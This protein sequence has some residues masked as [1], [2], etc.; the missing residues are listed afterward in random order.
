MNR[1]ITGA[2]GVLVSAALLVMPFARCA[3]AGSCPGIAPETAQRLFDRVQHVALA[4]GYRL[5]GVTTSVSEVTLRWSLDG[6]ECPPIEAHVVNCRSAFGRARLQLDVPRELRARCP[7]LQAVVEDLAAVVDAEH[8]VG[9]RPSLPATALP[10]FIG[11]VCSVVIAGLAIQRVLRRSGSIAWVAFVL[12][13]A[14]PFLFDL[15][16][17]VNAEL[18][19]AWIVFVVLLCDGELLTIERGARR[20][21]VLALFGFSAVLD[22][23]L[24]SGGPGDLKMN[25]AAIWSSDV[26]L[27]WGPAPVAL[28]RLLGFVLGGMDDTRIVW[29]SIIMSSLVPVLSYAIAS[30]LG[31]GTTA[32]IIAGFV[33]AAHPLLIAFAGTMNRQAE[34]LFAAFGSAVAVLGF[35]EQGRPRWFVAFVLGAVLAVTSRPEGAHVFVL[36]LAA[37]LVVPADR[38]LRGAVA[39]ALALLI[40]LALAYSHRVL[41]YGVSASTFFADRTAI[42]WTVLLS[43]DFTPLAWIAAWTV[44]VLVGLRRRP[45]WFALLAIFGIDLVWRWA[46]VYSMFVGYDRQVASARYEAILLVPL[47]IGIA[48]FV[49]FGLH[50][51]RPVRAALLVA[52]VLWTAA[53]YGRPAETMLGPFTVDQEFRFLKKYAFTLP[54]RARLY[55]FDSPVDDIGFV[56]AQL[57][58]EFVGSAAKFAAWSARRCD[59]LVRDASPAYLYIGSSCAELVDT[60]ERPLPAPEY[61]RWLEECATMRARIGGDAVEEM[62]VP[63]RK[64]SWHAFKHRTVRL[65]VYRLNDPTLCAVGPRGAEH[66]RAEPESS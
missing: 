27:R 26:E 59:D 43:R 61:A 41:E 35:L 13:A 37:L 49:D 52:F 5:E 39:I 18:A 32:A 57:V 10:A 25:L 34:Y 48:L 42:L 38:R 9:D 23:S 51:T 21:S 17:A 40:A 46:N 14:A 58:G 31:V 16:F 56:D 50:R 15:D 62:E 33:V 2:Y 20:L 53:T 22:W 30:R 54:P 4:P 29:C 36:Y 24:S 3:F 45:A 8:P 64:M 65:G 55:V 60:A 47:T 66:A 1:R 63:A 11:V 12:A 28:F 44:G 19:V 6:T 7:G